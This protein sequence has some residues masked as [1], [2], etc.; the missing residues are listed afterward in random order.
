MD[1]CIIERSK[2]MGDAK[3]K[4]A[5]S[6]LWPK[7]YGLFFLCDLLFWGLYPLSVY[8][9]K[10]RMRRETITIALRRFGRGGQTMVVM[11]VVGDDFRSKH[12]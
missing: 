4:F 9:S 2:D 12:S 5:F 3:Y 11:M 7:A 6:D 1:E 8:S 10:G